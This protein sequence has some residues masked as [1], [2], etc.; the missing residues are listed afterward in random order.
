LKKKISGT[1]AKGDTI[2]REG[3]L[4]E[5]S[6]Y[7]RETHGLPSDLEEDQIRKKTYSS[8]TKSERIDVL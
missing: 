4:D 8:G 7:A 1:P 3:K 5:R 2:C 6:L